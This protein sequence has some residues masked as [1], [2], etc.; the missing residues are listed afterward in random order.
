MALVGFFLLPT[1]LLAW[2]E[3]APKN[4]KVPSLALR[5]REKDRSAGENENQTI[6]RYP[7]SASNQGPHPC[8]QLM[9]T[10]VVTLVLRSNFDC[11]YAFT[12]GG[13]V[14]ALMQRRVN[15]Y[16]ATVTG[17]KEPVSG[18][19]VRYIRIR[20]VLSVAAMRH[21]AVLSARRSGV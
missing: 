16:L 7:T 4:P 18:W 14:A 2:V 15:G 12:L 10:P 13:A 11:D 21:G 20:G 1:K 6:R 8:L 9:S 19:K 3:P 5:S 17:L